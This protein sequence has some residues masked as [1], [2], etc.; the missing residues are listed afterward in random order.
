MISVRRNDVAVIE[1]VVLDV[2]VLRIVGAFNDTRID[3]HA[4]GDGDVATVNEIVQDY[5]AADLP[6]GVQV[7]LPVLEHHQR[8]GLRRIVPGRQVD[9]ELP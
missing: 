8:R 2:A 6:L 3:E 9:P 4:D 7:P 5:R 1:R